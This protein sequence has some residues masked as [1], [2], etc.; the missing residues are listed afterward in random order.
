MKFAYSSVMCP[1]KPQLKFLIDAM[2]TSQ[3][4]GLKFERVS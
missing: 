2:K 4:S 1:F 3:Q